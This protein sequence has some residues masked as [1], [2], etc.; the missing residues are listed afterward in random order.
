LADYQIISLLVQLLSH[1]QHSKNGDTLQMIAQF[2]RR[3][4]FQ[5]K[6]PWI[7]FQLESL[8][9]FHQ[10]LQKNTSNNSLMAGLNE[11]KGQSFA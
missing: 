2:F 6:Q 1:E 9:A 11:N 4:V 7:F 8:S 5:L 10:F 3:I